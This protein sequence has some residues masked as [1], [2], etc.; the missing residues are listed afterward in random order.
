MYETPSLQRSGTIMLLGLHSLILCIYLFEKEALDM[1]L[2]LQ[3]HCD[4]SS[5]TLL[6]FCSTEWEL[7]ATKCHNSLG[8]KCPNAYKEFDDLLLLWP[9]TSWFL[10][11]FSTIFQLSSI[12]DIKKTLI[13]LSTWGDRKT[14]TRRSTILQPVSVITVLL[15]VFQWDDW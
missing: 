5:W 15:L 7:T 3:Q 6:F 9:S 8:F 4:T 11:S 10:G 1:L 14:R 12:S 13:F 2:L